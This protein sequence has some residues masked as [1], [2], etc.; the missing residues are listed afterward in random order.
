MDLRQTAVRVACLRSCP[1]ESLGM[2][3]V[4]LTG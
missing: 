4:E 2:K 3:S 1:V